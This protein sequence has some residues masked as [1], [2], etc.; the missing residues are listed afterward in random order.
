[1]LNELHEHFWHDVREVNE[2]YVNTQAIT[3]AVE[4]RKHS[5]IY[6]FDDSRIDLQFKAVS[7][8]RWLAEDFDFMA[9]SK[10]SEAVRREFMI[11]SLPSIRGA[12]APTEE[13][14]ADAD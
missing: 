14:D 1:M 3:N 13:E 11:E 6:F 12:F 7:T 2:R 5:V 4:R 9:V 8:L 10:P